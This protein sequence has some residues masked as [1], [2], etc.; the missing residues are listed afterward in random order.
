MNAKR[1]SQLKERQ[2]N[3]P[4]GSPNDSPAN[5]QPGDVVRDDGTHRISD[6]LFC[7][8][9]AI[10]NVVFYGGPGAGDR[11]RVLVDTGVAG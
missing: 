11:E 1:L 8:R 10:V 2:G 3:G 4:A 7:K 9:L 6:D 5:D